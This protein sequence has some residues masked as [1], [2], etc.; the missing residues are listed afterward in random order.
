MYRPVEITRLDM[1][2]MTEEHIEPHHTINYQL[3]FSIL[4]A[5]VKAMLRYM[6]EYS[7]PQLSGSQY[8]YMYIVYLTFLY[9]YITSVESSIYCNSSSLKKHR[10]V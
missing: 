9:V 5:C 1:P 3:R 10:V 2:N 8:K 4:A 6:H 7:L